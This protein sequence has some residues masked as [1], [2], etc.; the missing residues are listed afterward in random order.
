M[1][2]RVEP[3]MQ[4]DRGHYGK[5]SCE[6]ILNLIQWFRRCRLKKKFKDDGGNHNTSWTQTNNI[7]SDELKNV[8]F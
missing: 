8:L 5:H 4:F 1:F 3:F 6:I 2:S 7:S